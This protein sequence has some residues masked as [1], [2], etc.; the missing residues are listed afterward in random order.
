[1][2]TLP[3]G[4]RTY[5]SFWINMFTS[6]RSW[7]PQDDLRE[8]HKRGEISLVENGRLARHPPTIR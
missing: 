7:L 4:S 8:M 3:R 1:M 2:R 6:N 5:L